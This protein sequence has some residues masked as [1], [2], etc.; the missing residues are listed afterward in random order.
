MLLSDTNER[1][2][3][4]N[5]VDIDYNASKCPVNDGLQDQT[6]DLSLATTH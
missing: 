6:K 5:Y 1:K 3:N 2:V 4:T